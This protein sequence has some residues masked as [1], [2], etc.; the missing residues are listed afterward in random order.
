MKIKTIIAFLAIV[1]F[2]LSTIGVTNAA[3]VDKL[4]FDYITILMN[5]KLVE[6]PV[7]KD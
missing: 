3:K 4:K 1:F 5:L 6:K 7:K 2:N